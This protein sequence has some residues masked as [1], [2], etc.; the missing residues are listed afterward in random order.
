MESEKISKLREIQLEAVLEATGSVRDQKD[1]NNWKSESGRITVTGSKFFNHDAKR[2]GGG[3]ID[4]VMHLQNCGFRDAVAFLESLPETSQTMT[5][6]RETKS[7]VPAP[8]PENWPRV[9]LYL[10]EVR[11]LDEKIIDELHEAGTIYA[12]K[13]QNAV[14]LSENGKGAELRG[15]GTR[16]FH[17]YRGE[18]GPFVI[19]GDPEF[20]AFTESAV[21]AIS[22]KIL[23]RPLNPTVYSF[24]GGP[25][26]SFGD[27]RLALSRKGA[28]IFLPRSMTTRR[29]KNFL[30]FF[31][32]FCQQTHVLDYIL[33]MGS[34]T[35][36]KSLFGGEQAAGADPPPFFLS[37]ASP[38]FLSRSSCP[39]SL[40]SR[41]RQRRG[42][43][44]SPAIG[45]AAG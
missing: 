36:T 17:G 12:D 41:P 20:V 32:M 15:T 19:L 10:T 26:I 39:D 25:K 16:S 44:T 38:P 11:C 37:R 7:V 23:Q 6:E 45:G 21:D 33:L 42:I 27:V 5:D 1:R 43:K 24:A 40:P 3:A 35:G 14:F 18:K 13:H 22:F 4:L 30:G 29:E 31:S 2:G 28:G 34:R 8:A 9:R